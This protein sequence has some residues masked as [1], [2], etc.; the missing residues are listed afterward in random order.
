LVIRHDTKKNLRSA[1]QRNKTAQNKPVSRYIITDEQLIDKRDNLTPAL[2]DTFEKIHHEI[3]NNNPK[4]AIAE[5]EAL[6]VKH[7]NQAF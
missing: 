7:P 2:L 5:L 4:Q 3:F 6:L 1:R